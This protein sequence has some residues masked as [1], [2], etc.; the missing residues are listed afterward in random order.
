MIAIIDI[1]TTLV[2]AKS[3]RKP[4]SLHRDYRGANGVLGKFRSFETQKNVQEL[5]QSH[6]FQWASHLKSP[7]K[8]DTDTIDQL[9][10]S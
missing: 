5:E 8:R 3:L 2:A 6:N 9:T 1:G 10:I 7:R 4:D